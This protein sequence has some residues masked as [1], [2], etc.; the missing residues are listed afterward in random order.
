MTPEGA[1][2][3]HKLSVL[4]NLSLVC[5]FI[6]GFLPGLEQDSAPLGTG[7]HGCLRLEVGIRISGG[8]CSVCS[9]KKSIWHN[10]AILYFEK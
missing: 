10:N 3:Y 9:K 2:C 8:M 5:K 4:S 1:E 7:R 6:P